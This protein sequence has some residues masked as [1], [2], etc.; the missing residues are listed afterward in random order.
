MSDL[1]L[2]HY[3]QSPVAEKVRVIL[4]IKDLRWFSVEIPRLPPKPLLMPLT[5][6]YRRTPVLQIGADIYCDSL[7]IIQ[8]L[9]RRFPEPTLFPGGANG[10]ALGVSRWTDGALFNTAVA[11]VLGSQVSD[12]PEDFANDRARLY[13]GPEHDLQSISRD[14]PHLLAQ[15]R[16]QLAWAEQRLATGRSFMLGDDPGLPDALMYYLV[17]FLRG[18]YAGGPALLASF[19]ALIAWE[20]RVRN[21]GHGAAEYMSA[22]AALAAAKAAVTDTAGGVETDDPQQ[23]AEGMEVTV[24][25]DVDGGD[26]PVRGRL[27]RADAQTVTLLHRDEAVDEVAIHFP[28]VGYRIT[29][30][31]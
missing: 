26:P 27:L 28:R 3:P 12:L 9:E 7:C 22:Q 30:P 10:M 21:L 24:V 11:V 8:E 4:G 25:A 18:R 20:E 15:L 16:G 13:F 17:W 1:I 2:H 23:L 14:L 31:A 6:G 19:D 5:G 29:A